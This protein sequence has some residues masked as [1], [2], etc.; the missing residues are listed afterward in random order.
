M[1]LQSPNEFSTFA[2]VRFLDFLCDSSR[3]VFLLSDD[4]KLKFSNLREQML[5]SRN[6][7]LK[8]LQSFA[9]K[10]VSFSL[11]RRLK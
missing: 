7:G 11:A 1:V 8:M 6:I 3:Q 5:V 4:K 10:V 9:R 2:T